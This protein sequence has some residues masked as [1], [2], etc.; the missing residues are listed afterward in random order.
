[1]QLL[2]GLPPAHD[3]LQRERFERYFVR[4][5]SEKFDALMPIYN[6]IREYAKVTVIDIGGF[7]VFLMKIK[8]DYIVHD[9]Y[10]SRH[11]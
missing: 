9:Y 3:G 2:I 5:A 1:M 6:S 4:G 11:T 7:T 10:E 8:N